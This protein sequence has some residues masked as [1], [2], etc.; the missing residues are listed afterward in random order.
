MITSKGKL[1]IREL[2]E[3][4]KSLLVQWLSNPLVLQYYEGRDNP[5]DI[6]KVSEHFYQRD[7]DVTGCI[8]EFEN[9]AIGYIQ[10]Y[11]LESEFKKEYGYNESETIYGTDQFIGE[12]ECWNKGIGTQVVKL[13]IAYLI[14]HKYADKIVMD[15]Q[16]WNQRA[17]SCYE[18]CGFKKVKYLP[19]HEYHEG[20]YQDC[21]LI[22]YAR[23]NRKG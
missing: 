2:T 6:K 23:N 5:H 1:N 7:N 4:D 11:L 12:A 18:K 14:Q 15:P 8:I 22:E 13:M 10:F 9:K 17:L 20:K 16:A 3:S 21:W 19:Q